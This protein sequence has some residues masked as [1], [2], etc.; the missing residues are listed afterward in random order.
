ML[1]L[2]LLIFFFVFMFIFSKAQS[3][4]DTNKVWNVVECVG[5]CGTST[6]HFSADTTIGFYQYKRLMN[7]FGP[8]TTLGYIIGAREDTVA[9]KVYFINNNGEYLAYDFSLNQGDTFSQVNANFCNFQLNVDSV[10]TVTL[11]NGELRKR[12][13]L[14]HNFVYQETWIEGIG[15]SFG[16]PYPGVFFCSADFYPELNCFSEDGILKYENTNYPNCNYSSISIDEVSFNNNLSI[17][18]NP[19]SIHSNLTIKIKES[20]LKYFILASAAG[21]IIMQVVDINK[22]EF[23]LDLKDL[24]SGIYF[25]C[26]R[27]ER[28]RSFR[29]KLICY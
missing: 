13:F 28:G 24:K 20:D 22:N 12:L 16:M 8:G 2:V 23:M 27:D 25:I 18:P 26:A 9:K 7:N 4:V 3:L 29:G 1:K 14:S 17:N 5:A 19:C 10:D 21:E 6:F 11:L 15:S